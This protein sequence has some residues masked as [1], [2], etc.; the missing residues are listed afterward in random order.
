MEK[1]TVYNFSAGPCILP[2][3]VLQRA[4]DEMMDWHGTGLSV[5][6]M[7]HR[8]K[9][10]VSIAE[11]TYADLRKLMNIPEDFTIMMLQGG[12]SQQFAA[13][14]LNVLPDGGKANYVT[15]GQWSEGA[16]KD[17]KK[18]IEVTECT[19]NKDLKFT[20]VASQDTWKVDPDAKYVHYCENETIVGV[21][22]TDNFPFEKFAGQ[23][24]ICDMSSNFCSRPVDW[25]K[26]DVVYAGAQKNVGP[27]GC[28]I[29]I[30]K[31]HL[32]Q[33][34]P[35]KICPVTLEWDTFAKAATRFHNTPCCYAVYMAGLNIEHMLEKGGIPAM[36][37]LANERSQKFYDSLDNSGGYYTNNVDKAFRSR[38]NIPFRV[39]CNDDLEKKF[40]AEAAAEGLV[41]LAGH[42]S[43]G[44]CRA[45]MYNAM[46]IE[47]VDALIAFCEK[48]KAANP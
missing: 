40:V 41:D 44:G 8:G 33:Q 39:K 25:S 10:F 38:M 3:E 23:L 42:R 5:L 46:P 47:G 26:Y 7:S 4:A 14:P 31:N 29:V 36:E 12:A 21:E 17:A 15:T 43:I 45:S 6:E 48:F 24:V 11:K 35:S 30:V 19:N 20:G 28:T 22:F 13:I 27:S 34:R 1:K 37:K 2:K 16:I 32:L 18:Y 9:A